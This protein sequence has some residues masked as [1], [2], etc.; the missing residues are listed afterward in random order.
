MTKKFHCLIYS[1]FYILFFTIC[2]GLPA[3][4]ASRLA[5]YIGISVN[6]NL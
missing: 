6:M 1:D 3:R 5:C 2:L 4:L